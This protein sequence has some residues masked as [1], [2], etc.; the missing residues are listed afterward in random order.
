MSTHERGLD[1]KQ[2]IIVVVIINVD[3]VKN[4]ALSCP[5]PNLG[6]DL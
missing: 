2:I 3:G 5:R 6:R 4:R 1:Y